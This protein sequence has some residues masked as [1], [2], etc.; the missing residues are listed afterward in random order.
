LSFPLSC[1]KSVWLGSYE[2]SQHICIV[3]LTDHRWL[4]YNNPFYT[5]S[6]RSL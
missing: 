4:L 6:H 2:Y 1:S 3:S 5:P